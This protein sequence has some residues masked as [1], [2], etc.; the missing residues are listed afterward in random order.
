MKRFTILIL[1]FFL[2]PLKVLP[3]KEKFEKNGISAGISL[4]WL[5]NQELDSYYKYNNSAGYHMMTYHGF[6]LLGSNR[7]FFLELDYR[8]S[9]NL[10][11]FDDS[12]NGI[13]SQTKI[14]F[15]FTGNLFKESPNAPFEI[16]IGSGIYTLW[17]ERIPDPLSG[18]Q[19]INDGF[20]AYWGI[21]INAGLSYS[22]PIG[23]SFVG[24]SYRFFWYPDLTFFNKN[25]V[26]EFYST[27]SSL[28]INF[29]FIGKH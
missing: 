21:V 1:L 24:M 4:T 19:E 3:Q 10:Y 26:P 5:T 22:I 20:G 17:Q 11:K 7:L 27:G 12:N 13:T 2:V 29:N 25:D 28:L 8:T 14:G 6:N 18:L 9:S 15:N 23:K 16:L